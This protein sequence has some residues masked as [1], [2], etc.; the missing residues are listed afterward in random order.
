MEKR[1]NRALL[2]C[3]EKYSFHNSFYNILSE[4]SYEVEEYDINSILRKR[5]IKINR[6]SFR[7]PYKVRKKWEAYFLEKANKILLEIINK[8][9]PGLILVYN[10]AFLLPETCSL[11]KRRSKL[12]FFMGD[13]P[14]YTP[15]N[16]YYLACLSHADLILS[17]DS[18]WSQQLET[19]GLSKTMYFIPGPDGKSYFR[20]DNLPKDQD[21]EETEILYVGSSYLNSWGYKKALLMS[22][23]T[24]FKFKLYGNSAWKRWFSFFPDLEAVYTES[25]FIPQERLN[26]MFNMTKLIP[27]DGN[28]G[29]LNGVHLRVG[30]A[31]AAGALPL[32]EY[33]NDVDNLLFGNFKG[34][35][36]II[37]DYSK[38]ADIVSRYLNNEQD[39][40]RLTLSLYDYLLREYSAESNARRLAGALQ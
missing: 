38:S 19:I 9:D 8:S 2:L 1:F 18:F 14:F 37:N 29:I 33:R 28:P 27:V 24:G 26:R 25:G 4:I 40:S 10:S 13:S 35:L 20:I 16:N 7:L 23:F 34:E 30:E 5:D 36:P 17:P 39:R 21:D 11:M 6:Q 15:Q 31:L 32:I 12:V 3:P 22:K